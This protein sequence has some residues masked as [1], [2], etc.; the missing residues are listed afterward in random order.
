MASAKIQRHKPIEQNERIRSLD[1]LRGFA[2]MGI[3]IVNIQSFSMILSAYNN[4]TAYGDFTGANYATWF[5][6]YVFFDS[7]MMS[8]FSM[9]FGAGIVLMTE[10]AAKKT[11]RPYWIHCRRMVWLVIFGILHAHLLWVGDIL[12]TYG[13]CGLLVYWAR[14][15]RPKWLVLAGILIIAVPSLIMLAA[16]VSLNFA[17]EQEKVELLKEWQPSTELVNKEIGYYQSDWLTQMEHR[18]P[19][20]LIFETILFAMIFFWR[21]GGLMLLGMALYKWKILDASKSHKFYWTSAFAFLLLGFSVVLYGVWRIEKGGWSLD[22]TMLDGH[23][24]NYWGSVF[25]ALGYI[26][27]LMLICKNGWLNW[28]TSCFQAAGQMAL[29]NYLMQTIV[30]TTI[31]YGHGLGLFGQLS[32]TSQLG[33]V[34]SIWTFQLALSPIWMKRFR[35]GPF[36]WLWRSLVYWHRQPMLRSNVDDTSLRATD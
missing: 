22:T 21:A 24:F 26:S 29:T 15:W 2:L 35:F 20:A 8:I 27:A 4:P 36:E 28:L 11:D 32:R 31:F 9:L 18:V 34:L 25:V 12:Y 16:D 6:T 10:R 13:L 23:Q 19:T 5:V 1:V 14:N 17:S 33:I 3:L 30:C 7:K